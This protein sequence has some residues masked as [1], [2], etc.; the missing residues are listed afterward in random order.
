MNQQDI[1]TNHTPDNQIQLDAWKTEDA[2]ETYSE[3]EGCNCGGCPG[4]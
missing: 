4:E 2:D 1:D 3:G